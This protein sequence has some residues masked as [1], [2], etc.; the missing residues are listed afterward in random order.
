[1]LLKKGAMFGLDARIALAIFGALSV[2]SGAALYSAIQ[3]SKMVAFINQV[4]EYGKAYYAYYLDT[5]VELGFA[6]PTNN[7]WDVDPVALINKPS[8]VVGWKGPYLAREVH[9]NGVTLVEP[10]YS[11]MFFM[12]ATNDTWDAH[13]NGL[14]TSTCDLVANANKPC[15]VWVAIENRNKML[16]FATQ[17]D[18]Y[19]DGSSTPD[20]GKVRVIADDYVVMQVGLSHINN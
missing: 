6:D 10:R 4:D 1:M 14:P 8:G 17:V 12:R 18:K 7:K 3:E 16:D 20:T 5:G 9:S 11:Y 19:V 13:D 15:F 2:I